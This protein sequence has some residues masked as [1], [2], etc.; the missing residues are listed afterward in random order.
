MTL[1]T[2]T[3]ALIRELA[4]TRPT[5]GGTEALRAALHARRLLLLKAVLVRVEGSGASLAPA[6]R[7]RFDDDWA[8]L[9][10][11]ERTDP[12]AVRDLLDYPM[13]GALLS[14]T[15]AA[16]EGPALAARLAHLSGLAA[17]AVIRAGCP[18]D[19]ELDVP[20]GRFALPGLGVLRCPSG[21]VRLRFDAG[22]VRVEDTDGLAGVRFTRPGPGTGV[23]WQGLHTLPGSTVVLDDLDPY[24]VPDRGIGPDALPAAERPDSDPVG[25]AERWRAAQALLAATDPGRV[26]ETGAVLRAVVP[27]APSGR[28][29][30]PPMSATLRAAPGALLSQLPREPHDLAVTLVHETQHTKLASLHELVPLH[31]AGGARYRVGWRT[32]PR[33]VPGV[34]QGVYAHLALTDLWGRARTGAGLGRGRRPRAEREFD[35]HWDQ[36]GKALSILRG[37]DELTSSGREFVQEMERHHASLGVAART[38]G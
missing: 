3:S 12:S 6:V 1:A 30:G 8:L 18:A 7:R 29:A 16:P 28:A 26:A 21:R 23:G 2:D 34:L 33:P 17:A 20:S 13:T 10:R 22:A 9:E 32:D 36:V 4:R 11:A 24:R 14:E 38:V 35:T 27:L 31:R 19:R 25:W 5:P 15:L 37:S